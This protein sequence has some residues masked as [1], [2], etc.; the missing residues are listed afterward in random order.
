MSGGWGDLGNHSLPSHSLRAGVECS[1][2]LV[3]VRCRGRVLSF[4]C[5]CLDVMSVWACAQRT[6]RAVCS[7]GY[8]LGSKGVT[9]AR[10]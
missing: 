5:G 8:L 9:P 4:L 7:S 2:A 10:P 1:S 6:P 3:L